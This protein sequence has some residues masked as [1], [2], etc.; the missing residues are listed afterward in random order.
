MCVR[1]CRVPDAAC[2]NVIH[3]M[4][5]DLRYGRLR[6][7]LPRTVVPDRRRGCR[8]GIRSAIKSGLHYNCH[9]HYD[10]SIGRY[11][12]R[13]RAYARGQPDPL[14]FVDGPSVYGY[15]RG[16]SLSRVDLDGRMVAAGTYWPHISPSQPNGNDSSS[17]FPQDN[18]CTVPGG[19]G[20]RMNSNQCIKDCCQQ[21]DRCFA[22][23]G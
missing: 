12:L 18:V 7:P 2:T 1:S 9:R 23:H 15:V 17:T 19:I 11:T 5:V 22:Q 21:H 4:S 10:P 14:G 8:V 20:R 3:V 6:R 13:L 16:M